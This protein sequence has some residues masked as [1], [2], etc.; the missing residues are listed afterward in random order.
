M[1]KTIVAV[2]CGLDPTRIV[3]P[4]D[5]FPKEFPKHP[6]AIVSSVVWWFAPYTHCI[7]CLPNNAFVS[8]V[9]FVCGGLDP[10]HMGHTKDMF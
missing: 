4:K 10:T 7:L 3:H 6:Q 1:F 5:T 2:S 9:N 8:F